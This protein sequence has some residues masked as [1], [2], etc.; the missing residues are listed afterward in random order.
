MDVDHIPAVLTKLNSA[1]L[2]VLFLTK[3]LLTGLLE[4]LIVRAHPAAGESSHFVFV[5]VL[6]R[7]AV[8]TT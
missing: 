2:S 7:A 5:Y 1:T 8:R 3:K 4:E 6:E